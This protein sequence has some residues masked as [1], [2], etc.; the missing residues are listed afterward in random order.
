MSGVNIFNAAVGEFQKSQKNIAA[1]T[2]ARRKIEIAEAE[3][4]DNKKLKEIQLRNAERTGE[5]TAH[6]IAAFDA[7]QSEYDKQQKAILEG[8]RAQIDQVESEQA[9]IAE[10][11]M[12]TAKAVLD[13]DPDVQEYARG[14]LEPT[15]R[16]GKVTGY[17][18]RE[19]RSRT[20][21]GV[22]YYEGYV[23]EDKNIDPG[24]SATGIGQGG[25]PVEMPSPFPADAIKQRETWTSKDGRTL[26][27]DNSNLGRRHPTQKVITQKDIISEARQQWKDAGQPEDKTVDDYLD[28][29]KMRLSGQ[30]PQ[31][32]KED[33][34]YSTAPDPRKGLSLSQKLL[35][36]GPADFIFGSNRKPNVNAKGAIKEAPQGN[37]SYDDKSEKLIAENMKAYGK[38]RDEIVSALQRKGYLK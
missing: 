34:S 14:L 4:A 2:E 13:A 8:N 37:V 25:N 7:Q 10:K 20:Y 9:S 28:S 35:T 16:N 31:N 15:Y 32:K 5:L 33:I 27:I 11:A 30:R 36:S 23:P 29:A 38:S 22:T 21:G 24:F 17:K 18:R 3:R 26:M 6:Q 12:G 19:P 1:L